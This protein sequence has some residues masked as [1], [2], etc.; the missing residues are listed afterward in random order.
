MVHSLSFVFDK[1]G[2]NWGWEMCKTNV[3][4]CS[5]NWS[6]ELSSM[7]H[8]RQELNNHKKQ[9]LS[10]EIID[11]CARVRRLS[12]SPS[13]RFS[14]WRFFFY[15]NRIKFLSTQT[16][17]GQTFTIALCHFVLWRNLCFFS[18]NK[19]LNFVSPIQTGFLFVLF[20]FVEKCHANSEIMAV[21][22]FVH[23]I[24]ERNEAK[25][26]VTVKYFVQNG[27]TWTPT[28]SVLWRW[29]CEI[30][31]D[32]HDQMDWLIWSIVFRLNNQCGIQAAEIIHWTSLKCA[33][34]NK[35]SVI[36]CVFFLFLSVL[37]LWR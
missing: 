19:R 35:S 28:F 34:S 29:A 18:C 2:F 4:N 24:N 3:K 1:F 31:F 36:C 26:K 11:W 33:V 8:S 7:R 30:H 9:Q 12:C 20:I 25:R 27:S 37:L 14:N 17:D 16:L 32:L 22:R 5:M 21:W 10:R 23:S 6:A 15:P 13:H